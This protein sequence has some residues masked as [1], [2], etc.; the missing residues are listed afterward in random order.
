MVSEVRG[1]IGGRP[2]DSPPGL[3]SHAHTDGAGK[4]KRGCEGA[5]VGCHVKREV[6]VRVKAV[7][8]RHVKREVREVR[9]KAARVR[10]VKRE[11]REVRV[12]AV[13]VR[14]VKRE[15]REVRVRRRMCALSCVASPVPGLPCRGSSRLL[16]EI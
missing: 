3:Q 12:K 4:A 15:V 9:V 2:G 8:V 10:H 1:G 14:A 11:V 13:R 6:R 7:R 5:G 16:H